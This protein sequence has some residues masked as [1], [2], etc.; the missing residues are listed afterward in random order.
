MPIHPHRCPPIRGTPVGFSLHHV[1]VAGIEP[2]SFDDSTGLLRAHLVA[3]CRAPR[4]PPA[5]A[6][7][8]SQLN[9]PGGPPALPLGEPYLMTPGPDPQGWGRTDGLFLRQPVRAEARHL[10]LFSGSLTWFL[11]PRLASPESTTEVEAS[12]PHV[13]Y[14]HHSSYRIPTSM[15][16]SSRLDDLPTSGPDLPRAFR[17]PRVDR[18]CASA[19]L[20]LELIQ[21]RGC[22]RRLRR[23]LLL[24][25][26]CVLRR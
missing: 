3:L 1:E 8:L 19:T 17:M 13:K 2:A 21:R 25:C 16:E 15:G 9:F 4:S 5:A 11:K 10:F 6:R 14:Q 22:G 26:P 24:R 7:C 20:D 23:A 18:R 12:H